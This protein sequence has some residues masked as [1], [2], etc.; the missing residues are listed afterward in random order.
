MHG[1]RRNG[2]AD[3]VFAVILA[4][5]CCQA[6]IARQFDNEEAAL[7]RLSRFLHNTAITPTDTAKAVGQFVARRLPSTDWVRIAIDWTEEDGKHLLVAT[8]IV[9]SRGVPIA[10]KAYEASALKGHMRE[11]EKEFLTHLCRNVLKGVLRRR[12]LI[13]A[14][15]GF[16]DVELIETLEQLG[17][18]YLIRTKGNI[19]VEVD[20]QWGKLNTL[21]FRTNQRRRTFG[22]V[23]YCQSTP[24]SVFLTMSRK[25]TKKGKW[26]LWYLISNH[27]WNPATA[28]REYA[29]RW[30]CESGFRDAKSVLG[31]SKATIADIDAWARMF[32]IVAIAMLVMVGIGLALVRAPQTLARL[33]RRVRSRRQARREMSIVRAIA[34][35]LK[36]ARL[37]WDWLAHRGK[38]NF[39]G[40]L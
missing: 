4:R 33:F 6:A 9:G 22:Q 7:K 40:A 1:H 39:E 25:R 5:S 27:D 16:A 15:R 36:D 8:L 18:T 10:W 23:T 12:I 26:G 17:V 29:R 37:L 32:A 11:Y 28:A 14:D 35:L 13:T 30:N 19:K 24:R 38:L 34:D 2:F 3:F 21:R 20:G 31:F